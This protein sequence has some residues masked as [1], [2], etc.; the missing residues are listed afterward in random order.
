MIDYTLL[1]LVLQSKDLRGENA[2]DALVLDTFGANVGLERP[3]NHG[4]ERNAKIDG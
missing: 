1:A 4:T 3:F 2:A